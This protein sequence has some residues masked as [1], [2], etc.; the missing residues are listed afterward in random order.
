MKLLFV[1]SP[2]RYWQFVNMDDN[3]WM[4][5]NYPY[6]AATVRERIPDLDIKIIDCC[7]LRTGWRTLEKMINDER[8][9]FVGI[10]E[11]TMYA[12]EGERV[13]RIAKRAN[14]DCVVIGGGRH[15]PFL[16]DMYLGNDAPFDY[17][18]FGEGEDTLPELLK[19]LM[20]SEPNPDTVKG[21]IY[22]DGEKLVR[23]PFREPVKNLDDLPLPAYDLMNHEIYGQ[24]GRLWAFKKSIPVQHSRGCT[25]GCTYCSFWPQE[26]P[27]HMEGDKPVAS[28]MYRTKSVEKTIEEM[29]RLYTDYGSRQ[30]NWVDGTWN[31]N[32]EWN[33]KWATEILRRNWDIGWF[34]FMRAD[35]LLRDEKLGILEKQ[36]KSGMKMILIG[37]ERATTGDLQML[38]KQN[39]TSETAKE[40]CKLMARKYPQ[41]W[42]QCT[43]LVGFPNETR[44]SMMAILDYALES[45]VN[46]PAFH[47]ITPLPGTKFW[48]DAQEAKIIMERDFSKYDWFNPIIECKNMTRNEMLELYNDMMKKFI[49]RGGGFFKGLVSPYPFKRNLY[50]WFWKVALKFQWAQL[51][52]LL[53]GSGEQYMSSRKPS[54]YNA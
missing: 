37:A 9:D 22:H 41:V 38:H 28:P 39:Y 29:E 53:S 35:M 13:A 19:E 32:P 34:A 20:R 43:Y 24:R 23:T 27:W 8:A 15:Y 26:S 50:W 3:F 46:F 10:G 40:A 2:R 54:W 47:F 45:K 31:M 25:S 49:F 11:E 42:C 5:L 52:G 14:P 48:E 7:A 36:V 30:F 51:K 16:P 18:V 17:L 44:E 12:N 6:L 21:L 33:D 1:R 4:P